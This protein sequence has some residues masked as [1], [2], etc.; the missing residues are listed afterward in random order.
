MKNISVIKCPILWLGR[1]VPLS[2]CTFHHCCLSWKIKK[3]QQNT[4][5]LHSTETHKQLLSTNTSMQLSHSADNH[6]P[7]TGE[8]TP[9]SFLRLEPNLE[10]IFIAYFHTAFQLSLCCLPAWP[11]LVVQP[12]LRACTAPHIES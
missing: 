11:L 7:F 12:H 6:T 1:G 9:Y 2:H 8:H 3:E 4:L 5:C 10:Q